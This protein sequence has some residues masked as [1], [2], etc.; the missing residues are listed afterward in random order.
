MNKII[1]SV[2]FAFL[3]SA[4]TTTQVEQAQTETQMNHKIDR[5]VMP[6]PGPA[7]EINLDKPQSF[8]LDNGLKVMVVE[9]HKLPRVSMNLTLDNPPVVEGEKAGVA[10]LL[11]SMLGN[12]TST[13]SKD[14][15][16]EE[17]D[18]YGAYVGLRSS[19]ASV[20]SLS[21]YFPQ[22]L[23]LTAQGALDPLLTQEEFDSEKAKMLEGMKA[24]AKNVSS[25]AR[26]VRNALGFGLTHP[27]GEFPTEETVENVTLA[28]VRQFYQENFVP[29][30]AYLVIVGDIQFNDAQKL[31]TEN[32][33]NWKTGAVKRQN[34]TEPTNLRTA[35]IDFIDMP[36][37]VQSEVATINVANVK[38]TSPDFYAAMMANQILGGGGEGRLFLNL[39]ETHGWTYGSYS[40]ISPDKESNL[41]TTTASVRNAVTDSAVVEMLGELQRIRTELVSEE[42]LANAKAK[43]IGNYVM[44]V[45]KPETVARFALNKETQDLPDNFYEN[46]IKNLNAV[47][48]EEVRA[49]AQKYFGKDNARIVVVGKSEDVLPALK[50]LNMPINYY[51]R[52]AQPVEA[53]KQVEVS[54]DV[55]AEGVINNYLKA[56][57]GADKAKSIKTLH[58]TFEMTGAAPQPIQGQIKN[59]APNKE[60][61]TMNM[62][63]MEVMKQVFDGQTLKISGMMGSSEKS[64]EDVAAQAA[65]K[66]IIE[67]AFYTADQLEIKG[68][69]QV[70]GKDAYKIEV[71]KGNDTITEYYD[72][73]SYLL[74]QSVAVQK[75]PQGEMAV[76]SKFKD[77]KTVEGIQMPHTIEQSVG[78]Q[79][80]VLN[81][82]NYTVNSGV[83]ASDFE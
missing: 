21:K 44:E 62:N 16:N 19:G 43:Y 9:N 63:G 27:F 66:G 17:I 39:R 18:F 48:P 20:S 13:M 34:F 57:G 28:D 51:N 24:D 58:T 67:Q 12:G 80:M 38:M 72:A 73:S 45:E 53:P 26:N 60:V 22:I 79:N 55:T 74:V 77:Y 25:V 50:K 71:T 52:Y 64:G 8:T 78:P 83:S 6:T 10:Q 37:A 15:Y 49:A 32:F 31:V 61:M 69:S 1:Y 59:M 56:I 23:S 14:D 65:K 7:P 11:S 81:I 82:Q 36:N 33:S 3:L 47:T 54:A 40:R 76:T 42:E 4:C 75:S 2:M 68:M 41:F 35:Q 29:G 5:S 30:N 46:Y 70:D